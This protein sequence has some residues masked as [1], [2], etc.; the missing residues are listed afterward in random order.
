MRVFS[1]LKDI[2]L[3]R[4]MG[5]KYYYLGLYIEE[6]ALMSLKNTSNPVN[7]TATENG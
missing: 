4:Q 7:W 3:A 2:S 5:K 6:S 1:E